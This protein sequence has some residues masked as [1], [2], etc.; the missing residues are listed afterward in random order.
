MSEVDI[1][2]RSSIERIVLQVVTCESDKSRAYY[3]QTPDE[4]LQYTAHN[5]TYECYMVYIYYK[6]H[7]NIPLIRTRTQ[8][9][10]LWHFLAD[11]EHLIPF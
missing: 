8:T 7:T 6:L 10:I 11:A 5:S 1:E 2:K 3:K 4:T 9:N